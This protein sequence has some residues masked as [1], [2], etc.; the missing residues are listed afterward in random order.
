M[1]WKILE[2]E[3]PCLLKTFYNNL[4]IINEKRLTIS[5]N[6][7]DVLLINENKINVSINCINEL[8]SNG[9]CI[10]L[11][12]EKKLPN[13][14]ILGY[15][16]QKQ[17][18]VNFLKQLKWDESYKEKCWNWI[19]NIK[20]QNQL[21]L[22]ETFFTDVT[23]WKKELKNRSKNQKFDSQY[24]AWVASFFFKSL[25]G[26][27]FKRK[28]ENTVN[29][30]LDYG[31]TILTN[32]VARSIVKK[33]L[34]CNISFFH[35]SIYSNF[36]LA[37]DIVEIFRISIDLFVKKLFEDNL[38]KVNE[39]NF[40][41]DIKYCLTEYIANFKILI[42]GKYEFIN[43]AIDKVIDWIINQDFKDHQIEYNYILNSINQNETSIELNQ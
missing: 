21:N 5:M 42:D 26:S 31:Y 24:E 41:Q 19:M 12:N 40:N 10:I 18:Y 3:K 7:I 11:C 22:L 27:S 16:V 30:C 29:A 4:V 15:K 13:S 6:D 2:I 23:E 32:M 36:P 14:Y 33:G 25:Y 34:H 17:S 38:I 9:V 1:G 39:N 35:G 28:N 37:Y 8:V 43:N 20:I